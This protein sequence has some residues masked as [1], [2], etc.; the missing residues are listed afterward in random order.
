MVKSEPYFGLDTP[1]DGGASHENGLH[2]TLRKTPNATITA[3]KATIQIGRKLDVCTGGLRRRD[4][5]STMTP[6][7]GKASTANALSCN[8]S[9]SSPCNKQC[10]ARVEP[11]PGQYKPVISWNMH[12]G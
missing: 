2:G 8:A 9:R 6:T 5:R 4:R 7:N 10:N 3:R 1:S 12:F 11:Q